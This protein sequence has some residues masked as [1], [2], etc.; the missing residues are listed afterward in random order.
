MMPFFSIVFCISYNPVLCFNNTAKVTDSLVK[1]TEEEFSPSRL[2]VVV[3][4][5]NLSKLVNN[6]TSSFTKG[7]LPV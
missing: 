3:F 1:A 6:F 4:Q 2:I 5:T 7:A